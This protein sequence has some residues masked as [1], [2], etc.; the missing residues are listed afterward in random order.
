MNATLEVRSLSGGT[1]H[2]ALGKAEPDFF[3]DYRKINL[4]PSEGT[5]LMFA[6]SSPTTASFSFVYILIAPP[7]IVAVHLPFNDPHDVIRAFKQSRRR[8]DGTSLFLFFCRSLHIA[9]C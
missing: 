6:C 2:V 5:S 8:D 1:R 3:A 7:V 4:G 9:P